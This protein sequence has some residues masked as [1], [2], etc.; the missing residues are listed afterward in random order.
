MGERAEKQIKTEAD[1]IEILGLNTCYDLA[2]V[3]RAINSNWQAKITLN[4]HNFWSHGI[5]TGLIS[6]YMRDM[7]G[8]EETGLEFICGALSHIGRLILM[9]LCPKENLG[10]WL[11]AFKEDVPLETLE[12]KYYGTSHNHL[13]AHWLR[14]KEFRSTVYTV[15]DYLNNPEEVVKA[16][17]QRR[18]KTTSKLTWVAAKLGFVTKPLSQQ[19]IQILTYLTTCSSALARELGLGF[20]GCTQLDD[21]PWLEQPNTRILFALKK[22]MVALEDFEEFFLKDCPTL[23]ELPILKGTNAEMASLRQQAALN[24]KLKKY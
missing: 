9:E 7:L 18:V 12:F 24:E 2:Q 1:A 17:I 15:I 23:P 21:L 13:G 14:K 3:T 6:G 19:N 22:N 11:T 20:T 16:T 10:M 5:Y 4:H 8:F